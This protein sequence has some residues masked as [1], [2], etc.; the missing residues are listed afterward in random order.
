MFFLEAFANGTCSAAEVWLRGIYSLCFL[1]MYD[2]ILKLDEQI[3]TNEVDS[4]KYVVKITLC[5]AYNI[6][7]DF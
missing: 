7:I 1:E 6:I 2:R 4:S 3:E 5:L